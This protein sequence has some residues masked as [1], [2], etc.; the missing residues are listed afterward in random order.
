M[1]KEKLDALE[2]TESARVYQKLVNRVYDLVH[3]I[4]DVLDLDEN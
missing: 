3:S 2:W 4:Q 1:A